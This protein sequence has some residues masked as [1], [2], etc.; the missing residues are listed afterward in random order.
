LAAAAFKATAAVEA[1]GE[2]EAGYVTTTLISYL[3]FTSQQR[4]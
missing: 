1:A 4:S 3:Y 2:A